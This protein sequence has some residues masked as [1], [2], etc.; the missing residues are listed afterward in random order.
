MSS[1]TKLEQLGLSD[2]KNIGRSGCE[3]IATLL[4]DTNS[5]INKIE[6]ARCEIDND[7]ATILAQT[8]VGN[9][10]LKCLDLSGNRSITE[11]GWNA[12]SAILA[13]NSNRTLCSLGKDHHD[14]D[15]V[16]NSL[17]SLLKLNRAVDMEPLF[18]LDTKGD[19][20][21][22]KALPSVIDWFDRRVKESTQSEEIVNRIDARKISAIFQFACAMPLKFVPSRSVMLVLH[23]ESIDA[24]KTE[25]GELRQRNM[26]LEK[27]IDSLREAMKGLKSKDD[28]I[29]EL[30]ER[31][32]SIGSLVKKRKHG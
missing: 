28:E 6:L 9:T 21:K 31:M 11:S 29:R 2:N 20:R 32:D 26:D 16:P 19:E 7:C 1:N 5:N 12:F 23:K 3:S 14:K 25:N 17:A 15:F 18:E 22:P 27:E 24:L 30:Y 8:L 4:Q 10:K 13:N